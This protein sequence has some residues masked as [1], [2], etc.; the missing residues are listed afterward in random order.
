MRRFMTALWHRCE[1][2]SRQQGTKASLYRA[3]SILVTSF[4]A[5][6]ATIASAQPR[7]IDQ[8]KHSRWTAE[9]GA[10]SHILGIA[11]S[12]DGYLWLAAADGV[13]RFD[14]VTFEPILMAGS[15]ER[16]RY[17]RIL[18]TRSGKVWVGSSLPGGG[19]A[20]VEKG[21]LHPVAW[22]DPVPVV[23]MAED[24]SG[25]ILIST[26]N[27]RR[28]LF[29][30]ASGR[31]APAGREW[32]VPEGY[33]GDIL[34]SRDG[35][36]WLT[37]PGAVFSMRTN[38]R[39]FVATPK[40]VTTYGNLAEDSHGNLWYVGREGVL[41]VRGAG[42]RMP[43]ANGQKAFPPFKGM[44]GVAARFDAF[45][46][47]WLAGWT[48]G[49]ARISRDTFEK[50]TTGIPLDRYREADG[51]SS[52]V[53]F[54]VFEDRE[55]N[56]WTG[57]EQ[58][59][60]RFRIAPVTK[61][62]EIRSSPTGY[63]L[64]KTVTGEVFIAV[65]NLVY[66]I[67]PRGGP[68]LAGAWGEPI[69]ALCS[70]KS[71]SLI[72]LD[73]KGVGQ[74]ER[75]RMSRV[76]YDPDGE[77]SAWGC[78]E[79]KDG[80]IWIGNEDGRLRVLSRKGHWRDMLPRGPMTSPFNEILTGPSGSPVIKLGENTVYE[81]Q[82]GSLRPLDPRLIGLDAIGSVS[83]S[84]GAVYLTGRGQLVRWA[85]DGFKRIDEKRLPWRSARS[86]L[87]TPQGDTWVLV[88][89]A[90]YRSKSRDLQRLFD[91]PRATLEAD[92]FDINDGLSGQ[93][94]HA[95]WRGMQIAQ[96]AD[97]RVWFLTSAGVVSLDPAALNRNPLPPPVHIRSITANGNRYDDPRRISL[98]R[99]VRDIAIEYTA[100]S[101]SV[102]SRVRFRYKLEG[103]DEAW[104]EAGSRRQAFFTNLAPGKYRFRVL[105]SNN[106]G[107]WNTTG[108][109]VEISIAPT[110]AE[111]IWFKLLVAAALILCAYVLYALRMRLTIQQMQR[112]LEDRTAERER[113][114]REIHDTLLQ[115]WQG[116]MLMFQSVAQRLPQAAPERDQLMATLD[117][118][119]IVLADGRDKIRELR[120]DARFD[121]PYFLQHTGNR[122][123]RDASIFSIEVLGEPLELAAD[124]DAEAREI[125]VEA[126]R[127]AY[128]HASASRVTATVD[129]RDENFLLAVSDNGSGFDQNLVAEGRFGVV[130]MR[131]RAHRV[132]GSLTID[133]GNGTKVSFAVPAA[134]AYS[135]PR[136]FWHSL[137]CRIGGGSPLDPSCLA[138]ANRRS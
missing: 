24:Q 128:T 2:G 110:F 85:R 116:L 7:A 95:A 58:G 104:T 68:E 96:T 97:G 6:L 105:A 5:L 51:L 4:A 46:S 92:R 131:E 28:N 75:G 37:Q 20:Y 59:L 120:T 48:G 38:D 15:N 108:A 99:G 124:V 29:R 13:Y 86:I 117:Q 89:D 33:I 11:Q 65:D 135:R 31:I 62:T 132:G 23:R 71:G 60:D 64:A 126:L 121:L 43:T 114:A 90:I 101:L 119:E 54:S 129:Y 14:G 40:D 82:S 94:Q 39:H 81:V 25:N 55:G 52:D 8:Y 115:G 125:A 100:P 63:R 53:V 26:T 111:T 113:I 102:P 137:R 73:S 1:S 74:L 66:G 57:G 78:R 12:P 107:V 61:A 3:L 9:D 41:L 72:F 127:N 69:S 47:L 35:A 87:Q 19:L 45:G 49:V 76:A 17:G 83:E 10:P 77:L 80:A 134:K 118:A 34:R 93:E 106:D 130:G 91:D 18:V 138:A 112:R 22:R 56:I 79:G 67:V 42:A 88:R 136:N 103:E 123:W 21:T 70:S 16:L 36:L 98:P 122:L 109:G 50:R 27:P 133:S 44:R 84:P 30:Y 32:G